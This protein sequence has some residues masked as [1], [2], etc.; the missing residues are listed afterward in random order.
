MSGKAIGDAFEGLVKG[1]SEVTKELGSQ[2]KKI[3]TKKYGDDVIK[4][5]TGEKE[6]ADK[7]EEA[8]KK[9]GE[10]KTEEKVELKEAKEEEASSSV[11]LNKS[12]ENLY[13]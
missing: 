7:K 9:E 8:D 13:P 1:G 4:T 3:I 5:M 2:G 11:R 12:S 10:P 6:G